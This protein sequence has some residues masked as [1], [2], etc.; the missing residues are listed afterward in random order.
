MIA[1]D[2][3]LVRQALTDLLAAAPDLEVVAVVGTVDSLR[4]AVDEHRPD[5]VLT[6][7]R[8]P[9]FEEADGIGVASQL[10]ESHPEVGVVILSQYAEPAFALEL[11]QSG[12]ERRAYLL[13]E[14]ISNRAELVAAIEAV[15]GGGSVVD[16]KIVDSLVAE[17]SRSD[18]ALDQLTSREC[19]V[20]AELASGKSNAAIASSLVLTKRAVEKHI[21]AIFMKLD[22]REAEDVSSR[23]A[24]ALIY[25]ADERGRSTAPGA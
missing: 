14:R 23:V 18:S 19:E 7:I 8:M 9:P 4:E 10:R 1:D 20:L 15:A 24:A 25:L 11:F 16:P 3:F 22:L 2:S 12:S 5:V 13:K 17:R 21:N 6:D